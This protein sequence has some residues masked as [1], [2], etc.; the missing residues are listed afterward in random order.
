MG[1]FSRFFVL[2]KLFKDGSGGEPR[3]DL[4][5]RSEFFRYGIIGK[6]PDVYN[7]GIKRGSRG[8]CFLRRPVVRDIDQELLGIVRVQKIVVIAAYGIK[9]KAPGIFSDS[10]DFCFEVTGDQ[11]RIDPV[12]PVYGE[13]YVVGIGVDV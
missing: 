13:T 7:R 6:F 4:R 11:D 1:Y 9:R 8:L 2:A 12:K 10:V 3:K 5:N